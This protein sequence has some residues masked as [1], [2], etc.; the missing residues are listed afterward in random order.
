V[1]TRRWSLDDVAAA[2]PSGATIALGGSG[3][4]RKPMGLLRAIVAAGITDLRVVSFLGAIDVEFL[5]ASG[6]ASEIHTAGVALEGVGLAPAYRVARQTGTPQVVEWSEGSLH[7][8]L[9]AAAR[10]LPSLPSTTSVAS[11]LVATNPWLKV[12]SDPFEGTSV[13]QVRALPVDVAL[14]HVSGADDLGNLYIDGDPGLDGLLARCGGTVIASAS[15]TVPTDP[16]GADIS[17]IWVDAVVELPR[18]AWPT[19]CLPHERA[20]AAWSGNGFPN[21]PS[22]L[23]REEPA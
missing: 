2:V 20:T 6:A 3:M 13:V 15:A 17:R 23:L 7:T 4:Q 16:R 14:L 10:T 11:E 19:G 8:A 12:A 21:R 9:E 18:G 1:T 5:I 22:T